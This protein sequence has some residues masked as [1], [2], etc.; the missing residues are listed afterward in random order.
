MDSSGFFVPRKEDIGR[1]LAEASTSDVVL[2]AQQYLRVGDS[3]GAAAMCEAARASGLTDPAIVLSEAT[4]RFAMGSHSE[5]VALADGVLTAMPAHLGALNLKAH[6][7]AALGRRAEGVELMRRVVDGYADFPGA[8]TALAN[9]TMPGLH[10]RD[11]LARIHAHLQPRT[12]LEIGVES[13]ATLALARTAVRA[14][15]VDPVADR[16]SQQL[17]ENTRFY[18][19]ESDAFFANESRES[20]FDGAAVDLTFIDGMHW[21][22]YAL[23]DF[24]NAEQ[25]ASPDGVIAMHDC[26]AVAEPCAR[27]ERSSLFWVGDT[28]KALEAILDYRPDLTVSV[29]ATPPSGLVVVRG[30]VPGSQ[31]LFGAMDEIVA[32]YRHQEYPYSPERWPARYRMFAADDSGIGKALER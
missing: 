12:Y 14:A 19:V 2:F 30:L 23:R 29:I 3:A 13:G 7:E 18:Q 25:W 17:G 6:M 15:G 28:W 11:V 9:W 1:A 26:L 21:F 10:Y 4:A 5:A 32:R 31:V 8:L 16:I 27:R 22:E 24:A 20:V